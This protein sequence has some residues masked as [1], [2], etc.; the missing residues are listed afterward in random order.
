M[1]PILEALAAAGLTV[2]EADKTAI[3]A[4][5]DGVADD[6]VNHVATGLA[7]ALPTSGVLGLIDGQ[8][9]PK[10][11]AAEPALDGVVNSEI[12]QLYSTL[13]TALAN[14]AK[15]SGAVPPAGQKP[16]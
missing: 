16:A 8:L 15:A 11:I 14:A 3:E 4:A 13:E 7:N 12:D 5:C 2:L 6:A 10:I 9:K 1:N